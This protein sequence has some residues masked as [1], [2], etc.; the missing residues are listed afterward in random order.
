MSMKLNI[1]KNF[2]TCQVSTGVY[3]GGAC[4]FLE[5]GIQNGVKYE[6]R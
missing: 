3:I 6:I 1:Q 4:S 2:K 5:L